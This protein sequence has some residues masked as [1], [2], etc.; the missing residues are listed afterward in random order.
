MLRMA[1]T[2][3]TPPEDTL[4]TLQD[5]IQQ[6]VSDIAQQRN[7][8]GT[9]RVEL[10]RPT[11]EKF[12][13][14]ASNVALML[15]PVAR[16]NPREIATEV[17]ERVTALEGVASVDVAGPGFIN[18]TLDNEWFVATLARILEAGRRWGAGDPGTGEKI[19]LEFVSPN[20]TGPLVVVS[21]RHA[22][23]GDALARILAFAGHDVQRECYINDT[24]RQVRL[25]GEALVARA[26]GREVPEGGYEGEYVLDL[27]REL[28]VGGDDDPAEAGARAVD[29]MVERMVPVFEGFRL[30]FDRIQGERELHDTGLVDEA[31]AELERRGHTFVEDGATFLRTT[32]FG[33]DKD[34]AIVRA[35]GTPTY[36]AADLG[37]LLHKYRRGVDRLVYVL[38]ADHHGYVARLR[39]AA[40]ALG[41]PADSCE[42]VIMQM[43]SL[44]ENGEQR[45]MSKRRGDFVPM[46]ELI[47]RIGV[48]ASRY[49]LLQRS[50]DQA[51]DLD[52]DLATEQ[53]STNPVYYVQYAHAR[54]CSILR[55]AEAEGARVFDPSRGAFTAAD[56]SADSAG[57]PLGPTERRLVKRLAEL[58][59]AVRDA[60]ERRAPHRIAHFAHD[61]ASD[62]SQFYRDCRVVGDGVTPSQTY[63][64]SAL[65][66]AA[67]DGLA[68][69]LDLL[70]VA[71]PDSM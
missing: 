32:A 33:D 50:H 46:T 8:A 44:V 56:R 69:C 29:L 21:A 14:Y 36:F 43:V 48:D 10:S 70:G 11:E 40:Q 1:A 61:L 55:K 27:A 34:R 41:H 54:I 63:M 71:A 26:A 59:V 65:A 12:G 9:P 57:E 60:A 20:P 35:D 42:V 30:H 38:G 2:P 67:R 37:Y 68:T 53:D 62:F 4:G 18:L 3:T 49:F 31:I 16:A 45:K 22:A 25:F 13:D 47:D 7:A 66:T 58:P 52:L 17:A 15:A 64:R 19:L 24:G 23:Y 6:I 51:L 39:A 5:A 28:G